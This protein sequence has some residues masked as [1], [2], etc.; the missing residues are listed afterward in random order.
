MAGK[1]IDIMD[2][3]QLIRLKK[4]GLSNRQVA[5]M[6]SVSRNTINGYVR[7][8]VAYSLNYAELLSLKDNEL[9]DLFPA[10]SEVDH[11]RYKE[12]AQY[13]PDFVLELKRP[14]CTKQRLWEDYMHKHPDGY[15][16]SQFCYHLN[17]WLDKKRISGK[18]EHKYGEKVYI[19]FT[20][21]K[22]SVV[23]KATGE[24]EQ[25]EVFVAILP[26]S[27]LTFVKACRSQSKLDVVAA[28]NET[29]SYFG[30]VPRAIV[31][32]NL[33]AVVTKSHKY[34]P[35]I[36]LTLKDFALHYGCVIDP[37]RAYSPQDKA[38]VEGAVKLVYQR[39]FYPLSKHTFFSL[40]TLNKEIGL[41]LET[42][43]NYRFSQSDS[44]R[45]AEFTAYE[46]QFLSPLS[47]PYQIRE[48]R[49][50][51]VQKMG[52]VYLAEDKHYYSVPYRYIGKQVWI[53]YDYSTVEIYYQKQ[54]IALAKRNFR[55]G[56]YTTNAD[57]LSSSH[58][59]Y[60][61][62]S[63]E[64]FQAKAM[65]IGDKTCGYIT[66]LIKERD[67]PEVGYKQ[68]LGITLLTQSYPK[69]RINK[70]CERAH[71]MGK[72][73]YHI[74]ESMLK[75]GT[76]KLDPIVSKMTIPWHENI[77]GVEHYN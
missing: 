18:L 65:K 16:S 77:R 15:M 64:Y 50:I 38:L 73:N 61:S 34:A 2:L 17:K 59:A 8:V 74:I 72:H 54:R 31:S 43:N 30:G 62:W 67:Y 44:T 23:N 11:Y 63:L 53:C 51:T 21:K 40:E 4:D 48:F 14:G 60:S 22:L 5:E 12:L 69:E 10:E 55:K 71:G 13:F 36:N 35:I 57:H 29:L 39:I 41:L 37:T 45:R 7:R 76:D 25:M 75:N 27:Q 9:Y 33:K 46:K 19:D 3:R 68:A 52:Y 47:S 42:Y 56:K 26:A 58:K 1:R 32:D 6:L 49:K 24:L 70:A 20:G 66:Q 28:L